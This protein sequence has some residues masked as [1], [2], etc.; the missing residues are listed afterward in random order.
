MLFGVVV[1]G[2]LSV[3]GSIDAAAVQQFEGLVQVVHAGNV[4]AVLLS[5]LGVG[6]GDGVGGLF[7]LQIFQAVDGVVIT[8]GDDGGAVVG[9]RLGE[10]VFLGAL[11]GDVHAVDHD[12]VTASV[13]TGQQAVP[14][15]LDELRLNAQLLGNQGSNFHVIADEVVVFIVVGPGGPGALHGDGD[16]A[17]LPDLAQ[18]VGRSGGIGSGAVGGGISSRGSGR[19]GRAAAASQHGGG[20]SG[21]Q[22]Q[23][24]DLFTVHQVKLLCL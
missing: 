11:L 5:Q 21:G 8:L 14:L 12:V 4:G 15:A 17:A 23:G 19:S 10:V 18:Q 2:N 6:A 16:G 3:Q 20:N 13:Q 24:G 9:V 22:G 7:V 1:E